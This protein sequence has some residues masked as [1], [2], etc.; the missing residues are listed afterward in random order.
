MSQQRTL[1]SMAWAHRGKIIPHERF[2][3][4]NPRVRTLCHR[5]AMDSA[6]NIACAELP[7]QDADRRRMCEPD[8]VGQARAGAPG[9]LRWDVATAISVRHSGACVQVPINLS[10]LRV[11]FQPPLGDPFMLRLKRPDGSVLTRTIRAQ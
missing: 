9:R 6:P 2:R 3:R 8:H 1:T 4:R 5:S 11:T 7:Q 10:S